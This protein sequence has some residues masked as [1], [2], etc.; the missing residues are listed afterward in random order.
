MRSTRFLAV[1]GTSG[2][3]KSSLVR[4]GLIPALESGFMIGASST[5]RIAIC[6][7]GEDPIGRLAESLSAP[8]VLAFGADDPDVAST[9]RVILEAGLHRGPLGLVDAARRTMPPGEN[10]LVLVDQFEELFRFR[11]SPHIANS[12]DE[13]IAFVRL[14]LDASRQADIPVYVVLTMRSDFIGD[15]MDFPGLTEA[16]STGLFLVGRMSRDALRLA[17]TAPVAVAGGTVAPRLVNRVLNDL[18]DD[19]DQLPLVQHAL[20]R[21]WEYWESHPR[22]GAPMDVEDYEAVGTLRNALSTHAEE[23]YQEATAGGGSRLV[24]RLFKALTDTFSDRRGVRRPTSVQELAAVCEITETEVVRIVEI[25]RRP[26]RTFLMPPD[27]VAL[28]AHSIVDLSHESLMRCWRRL[29]AWAEEERAAAEF[30]TR[31]SQAAEWN[32]QGAAGLWRNPELELAQ[33]WKRENRPSAAWATRYNERFGDAMA[34]LDRSLDARERLAAEHERERRVRL[35]R[36]Q[37]T[38]GVLATLLLVAVSTA[39]VAFRERQRASAN[40]A[41]AREAVDESLSSV[42]RDP[43]RI[44]ADVPQVE[45]LRR[46]LLAKAEGFYRAFLAQEPH[47][48]ESRRDLAYAHFRLGHINRLLERRDDAAREYQEA[49][50]GFDALARAHPATAEYRDALAD[51]QNWMGETLRPVVTRAADAEAHYD[52][53]FDLQQ[54][55]LQAEPGN[56]HYRQSLARTRYNRGILLANEPARTGEAETDFREAVRL[57]QPLADTDESAAQELARAYNNLGA[58]LYIDDRRLGE[59]RDLWE[60]AIAT[61]ERLVAAHDDNRDYKLELAKFCDNLAGLLQS[62]GQIALADARS[63]QAIDLIQALA[64]LSPSLAVERAD[65]HSLRGLILQAGNAEDA[66]REYREALD[67]F[68][69]VQGDKALR[70]LPDFHLRF[71]D[72]L[73]N[74]A[75]FAREEPRIAQVRDLLARG[76][77]LYTSVVQGILASGSQADVQLAK[78]HVSRMSTALPEPYR[79]RLAALA[80]RL[81]HRLDVLAAG[82]R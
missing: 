62:Q 74:L 8:G 59:V 14:L 54:A 77:T 63:R 35:R 40:L 56:A 12:R 26:G 4:S 45:E 53:A 49:I 3:G 82:G 20:M 22:A 9:N 61:D 19:H 23:A 81:Q 5:W 36:V 39:Y 57:L 80:D 43:A 17:I 79:S 47:G 73:L 50:T 32:A 6:R 64:R 38:A 10:L 16:V 58:L 65:V 70:R 78:D 37:W 25:F 71:G 28:T 72:L 30:Y 7:P 29:I 60:R 31:L 33:R 66:V 11:R 41:L 27:T 51:A 2:S 15:C 44:G 48:E 24:E 52:R 76:V 46:D 34:F 68:A 69:D 13:A 21:T 18:G 42:D 55:L 67:A 75:R 1:V